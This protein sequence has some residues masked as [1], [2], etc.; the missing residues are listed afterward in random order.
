MGYLIL[1][2]TGSLLSYLVA[3]TIHNLFFH[4]LA[5]VPGPFL[6]RISSLPSFY[7]AVK[8][9]R[10]IWLWQ[11]FQIYGGKIRAAPNIVLFNSPSAYNSIFS[12]KANVKRSKFYDAWSRNAEDVNTLQT[13]SVEI[14]ARRRRLLN[15][16]FT[17]HSIKAASAF[18]VG[19]V[20]RCHDILVNSKGNENGDWSQPQDISPVFMYL[21]FDIMM[22]LSFGA[23]MNTKEPGENPFKKV[24]LAF[25]S[26]VTFN[27][28]IAK[29][30]LLDF[31]IWAKPRGLEQLLEFVI[32]TTIK[33][34]YAFVED[35][36]TKRLE[37]HRKREAE[38]APIGREDMLHFLCSARDPD[39]GGPAFDRGELRSEASLLIMAGSDTTSITIS[40]LFFY[41]VHNERAYL[42]L[43]KEIRETFAKPEDI[44]Y[45]PTLLSGCKYLRACIDETFRLSPAGPSELPREVLPG[46]INIDGVYCPAG[47]IVGTPNWAL[48]R[49]EEVYGDAFTFRPER[50]IVSDELKT[51]NTKESVREVKHALHSFLKGPGDCAGQRLA[52]LMMS[53]IVARTLW[54]MDV[55][56]APGTD[57][58]AGNAKLGW[59]SRD[60]RQ[61][62]VQDS[63][64]ALVHG[65]VVQF[66]ARQA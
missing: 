54:R 13:S 66:R 23:T 19:H 1:I 56:L 64:I 44:V 11:Q 29:S 17:D 52:M 51:L 55:R 20:D 6:C 43:V 21:V 65:P 63:Y 2:A 4:P 38:K 31:L 60:P 5:N 28:P 27:N 33:E 50:F 49:N 46:G 24:P 12:H 25:D 47:T 53:I 10:H 9:D 34:H 57:L 62:V 37:E 30:P 14:H 7:H 48:N 32:P 39:T 58:G 15:L 45:G 22:D 26:F 40:S 18:I 16:V 3:T 42:K 8:R 59:G 36:V 35:M 41:L 61:Q